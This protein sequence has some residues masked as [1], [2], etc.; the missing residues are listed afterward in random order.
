MFHNKYIKINKHRNIEA[1][2]PIFIFKFELISSKMDMQ[3]LL[4]ILYIQNA[5]VRTGVGELEV[6]DKVSVWCVLGSSSTL[7]HMD[8]GGGGR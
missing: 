8:M 3:Y 7:V 2:L 1:Y 5:M 6:S 4:N